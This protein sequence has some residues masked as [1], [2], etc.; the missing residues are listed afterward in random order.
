MHLTEPL[1]IA[2]GVRQHAVRIP[3][4]ARRDGAVQ[5]EGPQLFAGHPGPTKQGFNVTAKH[6][7]MHRRADAIELAAITQVDDML[8]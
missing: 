8:A 4:D 6:P 1:E 2:A 7:S 5:P 3:S